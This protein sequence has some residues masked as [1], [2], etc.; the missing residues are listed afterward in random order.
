VQLALQSEIIHELVRTIRTGA[1]GLGK[2]LGLKRK[3]KVAYVCHSLGCSMGSYLARMHPADL[4][5]IVVS[6]VGVGGTVPPQDGFV[7]GSARR[8]HP[9]RFPATLPLGYLTFATEAGRTGAFYHPGGFD[10]RIPPRDFQ[11]QDT[12]T[13]GE[14]ATFTLPATGYGGGVVVV[15]GDNDPFSCTAGDCGQLNL[16]T[17][18]LLFPDA[19]ARG[20]VAVQN[21]GH[22]WS[23]HYSA[24]A[25]FAKIH[26]WLDE[27]VRDRT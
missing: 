4:D 18:Q 19:A 8:L 27:E 15:N 26:E 22:D 17:A 7:I 23:L 20:S 25:A 13:S 10:P 5:A 24:P 12:L 2:I 3:L 21:S 16:L 1:Q 9:S 6:G 11:T 14:T